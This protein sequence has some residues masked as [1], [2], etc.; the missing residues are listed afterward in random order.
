M[1][2]R[3]YRFF[4]ILIT[5]YFFLFASLS[6]AASPPQTA[7][8]KTPSVQS[9]QPVIPSSAPVQRSDPKQPVGT[10]DSSTQKIIQECRDTV[11]QLIDISDKLENTECGSMGERL[12]L[13]FDAYYK[14][15]QSCSFT[16]DSQSI[17]NIRTSVSK[18]GRYAARCQCDAIIQ[19][20]KD[21]QTTI[22]KIIGNKCWGASDDSTFQA[23]KVKFSQAQDQWNLKCSGSAN[24]NQKAL[25]NSLSNNM[26]NLIPLMQSKCT[27]ANNCKK[28]VNTYVQEVAFLKQHNTPHCGQGDYQKY[29][30]QAKGQET[31]YYNTCSALLQESK[32]IYGPAN[33]DLVNL[34]NFCSTKDEVLNWRCPYIGTITWNKTWSLS[35]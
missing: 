8:P 6:W 17:L 3:K 20:G 31:L 14:K 29:L 9:K 16:N 18:M 5:T 1:T 22:Q 21:A 33:T 25:W 27:E 24:V 19:Q 32:S 26:A 13:Q 30:K 12:N 23:Q 34:S 11:K 10:N 7:S 4:A 2:W 28:V 15:T 35:A